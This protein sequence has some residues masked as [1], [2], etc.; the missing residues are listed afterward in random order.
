MNISFT[1]RNLIQNSFYLLLKLFLF[2]LLELCSVLC[3]MLSTMQNPFNISLLPSTKIFYRLILY[4]PDTSP[5]ISYF[6]SL[7]F[8]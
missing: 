6:L 5:K 7:S 4:F 2:W 3:N 1:L 8:Y